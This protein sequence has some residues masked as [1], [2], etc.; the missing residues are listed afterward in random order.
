MTNVKKIIKVL[1]KKS[2]GL[3]RKEKINHMQKLLSALN[4]TTMQQKKST[5]G[6]SSL[7]FD[8]LDRVDLILKRP[9]ATR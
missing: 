1:A 8:T 6:Y 4:I 3:G 7:G 2:K 9:Q 5:H